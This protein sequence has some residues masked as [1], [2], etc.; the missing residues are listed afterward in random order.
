MEQLP[1][2]DS[3]GVE[4]VSL[5]QRH[6]RTLTMDYHL[7]NSLIIVAMATAFVAIH[8]VVSGLVWRRLTPRAAFIASAGLSLLMSLMWSFVS[9]VV[10]FL[11]LGLSSD[12]VGKPEDYAYSWTFGLL[13]SLCEGL[14]RSFPQIDAQAC[15][16]YAPLPVG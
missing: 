13:P 8:L 6:H 1:A 9:Y 12:W 3:P 7:R 10:F 16:K 11:F 4:I 15:I 14:P 2:F 5:N